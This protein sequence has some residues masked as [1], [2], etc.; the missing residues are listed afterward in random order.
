LGYGYVLVDEK[1]R[2]VLQWYWEKSK[3]ASKI[4][5]A[6]APKDPWASLY[7]VIVGKPGWGKTSYAFYSLK[8][9]II[10]TLCFDRG[11]FGLRD[12][13]TYLET[14]YGELCMNKY[15]EEPDSIDREFKWAYYTGVTDLL[16][17][18]QDAQKIL[19]ENGS[20]RKVIFMDDLVTKSVYFMGGVW[21]RA[22]LAFREMMRVARVG[23]SVIIMTATSPTLIPEFMKHSS[24][25]I[26]VGVYH[27]FFV[28]TRYSRVIV[29]RED[30]SY[31]K[32]LKK[33]FE[34]MIPKKAIFG[35]PKWLENEINERKRQLIIDSAKLVQG[36]GDA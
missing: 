26:S 31:V 12:C 24:E 11:K 16:R 5:E 7:A 27:N 32:V 20:R 35:L 4:Y 13:V 23:A 9:G 1:S 17:F 14:K 29:P 18:I 15:C 19:T 30:G 2:V 8:T 10:R 36:G 6:L 28:Y 3:F 21:R 34:D 22:Y 33:A 25:Y